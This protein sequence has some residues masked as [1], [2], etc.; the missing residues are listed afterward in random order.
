MKETRC[1]QSGT[2]R[3]A[4]N[5]SCNPRG[6][7]SECLSHHGFIGVSATLEFKNSIGICWVALGVLGNRPFLRLSL[8]LFIFL[9]IFAGRCTWQRGDMLVGELA[10]ATPV[11]VFCARN[12]KDTFPFAKGFLYPRF[13]TQ[14]EQKCPKYI[15]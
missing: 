8:H 1:L 4:A 12:Y 13:L 11:R 15:I 3:L 14:E 10:T 9:F 2:G 7:M 5:E 6:T